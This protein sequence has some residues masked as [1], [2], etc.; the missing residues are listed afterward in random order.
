[1]NPEILPA[2]VRYLGVNIY[3]WKLR[4]NRFGP[5]FRR[6]QTFLEASQYWDFEKL[7]QY[8]VER[9]S[10]LLEDAARNV[11]F[12]GKHFA[13]CGFNPSQFSS[14][15]DLKRIEPVSKAQL[16]AAGELCRHREF[17]KFK[18]LL[19]HSS[20]TTGEKF[21]YYVPKELRFDLK[22]ATIWRQYSWAGIKFLDRRV[23]LGSR[24]FASKPPYWVRNTAENQ[25]LLS[26]H[27]LN[28]ETAGQYLEQIRRFR[29]VFMQGHPSGLEY[30]AGRLILEQK[31][32]PLKAVFTTGEFLSDQQRKMIES[33]FDCRIFEEYGQG[34]CVF[35][36]QESPSHNGLHEV[37]ELGL[38]EFESNGNG[39][40][41]QVIG[42][43]LWNQAMPFIRY[44][45]EDLAELAPEPWTGEAG[46]GLPVKIKR[47]IGRV[48]ENLTDTCGQMVLPVTV[49]SSIRPFLKAGENYQVAQ[50]GP[51][52]YQLRFV[53]T[54]THRDINK[55]K[56]ELAKLFGKDS[57]IE[58][59]KTHSIRTVGGKIRNV[60][61]E[62]QKGQVPENRN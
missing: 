5:A 37:S 18:P 4:N 33:A 54:P 32:I 25:L 40:L 56:S 55:L 45:I 29:P 43:S 52:D 11:P 20:G 61:N 22:F 24:K 13:D 46:L 9:L 50:V 42:T 38:I 19:C 26:I 39:K 36:A 35:A 15:E 44:R 3:G 34:E 47:I 49:R 58:F 28:N 7:K 14:L 31:T 10:H 30:L 53:G 21:A 51:K 17:K 16:R 60:V 59:M 2:W 57:T 27:H 1:M 6:Y 8:Q 12:Y 23:T 62:Y 48:D 41:K